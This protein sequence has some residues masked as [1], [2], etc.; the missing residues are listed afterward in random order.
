MNSCEPAAYAVGARAVGPL[1]AGVAGTAFGGYQQVFFGGAA[2][3][4]ASAVA[5]ILA[6]RAHQA[7]V[8][9]AGR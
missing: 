6:Q 4:A 8:S 9:R 2:L 1:L 3:C 5:L 7:E